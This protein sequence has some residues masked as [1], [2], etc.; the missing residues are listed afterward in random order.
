MYNVSDRA[1]RSPMLLVAVMLVVT[2]LSLMPAHAYASS[3]V[4]VEDDH[5][6]VIEEFAVSGADIT[7]AL[8]KALYVGKSSTAYSST[9]VKVPSGS[10]T[11]DSG[12]N[13][14]IYF[15]YQ[16]CHVCEHGYH[17]DRS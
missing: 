11:I 6:V 5:G 3:N 2:V 4:V 15:Q 7:S 10:Y 16:D 9:V 14:K 13:L 12:T 17:D 1:N 8:Q